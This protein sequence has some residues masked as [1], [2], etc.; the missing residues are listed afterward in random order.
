MR[1]STRNRAM[2]RM[3]TAT[4]RGHAND[5]MRQARAARSAGD[6]ERVR[7]VLLVRDEYTAELE[8]REGN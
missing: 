3:S 8:R 2:R 4:L 1:S 5:L 6:A 7:I